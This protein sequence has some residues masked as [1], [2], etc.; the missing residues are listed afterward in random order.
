MRELRYK[1]L[2]RKHRNAYKLKILLCKLMTDGDLLSLYKHK[3]QP[4]TFEMYC[5]LQCLEVI[6]PL[7][8][9][10]HPDCSALE[11]FEALMALCNLASVSESVRKRY[12]L[13]GHFRITTEIHSLLLVSGL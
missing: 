7:L 4:D 5:F 10:L 3:I 12:D 11:N 6:R 9:L 2:L 1:V 13:F 8:M